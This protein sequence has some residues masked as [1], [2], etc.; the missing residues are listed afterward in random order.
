MP[1]KPLISYSCEASPGFLRRAMFYVRTQ[2]KETSGRLLLFH[3]CR[4]LVS[5]ARADVRY[6]S[7]A[8]MCGAPTHVRFTPESGHVQRTHVGFGPGADILHGCT[9]K[10]SSC[11]GS[12]AAT[13]MCVGLLATRFTGRGK[14]R[15]CRRS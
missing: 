11:L 2:P 6:G 13:R 15:T 1:K 14:V 5:R 4:L 7:K 12:L 8:D 10:K 9:K 3:R